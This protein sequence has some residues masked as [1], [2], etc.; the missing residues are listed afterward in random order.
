MHP[1]KLLALAELQLFITFTLFSIFIHNKALYSSFGFDPRLATTSPGGGVQP[2]LIGLQ[3]FTML[4]DPIGLV[5]KFVM[6]SQ[7][8]RYEY[9]AGQ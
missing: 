1:T 7:T 5:E 3:L 2:F 9:Q 6:N 4:Q 8:R